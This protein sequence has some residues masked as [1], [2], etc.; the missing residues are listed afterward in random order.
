MAVSQPVF[1]FECLYGF[2]HLSRV[3]LVLLLS[4]PRP[5]QEALSAD[6]SSF[7]LLFM[8]AG[9]KHFLLALG[10]ESWGGEES[11]VSFELDSLGYGALEG[12]G[13][14]VSRVGCGVA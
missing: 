14:V 4:P 13:V 6:T 9:H 1:P 12:Q 11:T 10:T 3:G 8:L 2:C 5:L 7:V